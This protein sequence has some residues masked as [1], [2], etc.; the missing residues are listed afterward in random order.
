MGKALFCVG[1]FLTDGPLVC[2]EKAG[3]GTAET[4]EGNT[5]PA[6]SHN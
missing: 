1:I 4:A 3:D 6:E 2:G 5:I